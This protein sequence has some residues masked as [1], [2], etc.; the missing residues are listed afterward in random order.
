[1][2]IQ[3]YIESGI[4][5]RYAL[6]ECSDQE[7]AEVEALAAIYPEI[8]TELQ[9]IE[10]GLM[11]LAKMQ[12]KTA[13]PSLKANLLAAID[14]FQEDAEEEK[15][16]EEN[17]ITKKDTTEDKGPIS[18]GQLFLYLTVAGI[19]IWSLYRNV[20]TQSA[21]TALKEQLANIQ[22]SLQTQTASLNAELK[23]CQANLEQITAPNSNRILMAGTDNYPNQQAVIFWNAET[24]TTQL[25][26]LNLKQ[27]PED[28][29]YQ[30]WAIVEGK[31]VDLGILDNQSMNE[32]LAMKSVDKPEAFAI[33]IEPKGG[34]ENPT[35]E[36]MV[37]LGKIS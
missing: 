5:E 11:V 30:L 9:E 25:L 28:Q 33:T 7:I 12:A 35:L 24:S 17:S 2:D 36:K 22:D 31:A 8:K 15:L 4:L 27:L 23:N 34:S 18:W 19:A 37:V 14:D 20:N 13:P 32:V 26:N 6:G 16:A 29:S 1:M 21:Q 10:E 3:A